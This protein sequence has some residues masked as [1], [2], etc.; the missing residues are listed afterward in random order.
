MLKIEIINVQN[1]GWFTMHTKEYIIAS[2]EIRLPDIDKDPF[3]DNGYIKLPISEHID[4]KKLA[5]KSVPDQENKVKR[6]QYIFI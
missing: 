1:D 4:G 2:Y 5:L 6:K 3:D